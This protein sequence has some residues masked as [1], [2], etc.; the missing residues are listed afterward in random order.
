MH[1]NLLDEREQ[2]RYN[3]ENKKTNKRVEIKDV[4]KQVFNTVH[5]CSMVDPCIIT[6]TALRLLEEHFKIF[7]P[8]RSYLHL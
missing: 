4:G 6:T 5:R 1:D 3:D 2:I 7:Y 8:G